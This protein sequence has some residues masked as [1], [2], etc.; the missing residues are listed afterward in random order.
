MMTEGYPDGIDQMMEDIR[1]GC[2]YRL[3]SG[4][5]QDVGSWA[6]PSI[7][8]IRFYDIVVKED[9]KDKVLASLKPYSKLSYTDAEEARRPEGYDVNEEPYLLHGDGGVK[10]GFFRKLIGIVFKKIGLQT[11]DW[12]KIEPSNQLGSYVQERYKRDLKEKGF[13]RR[14]HC[15][16]IILGQLKDPFVKDGKNKGRENT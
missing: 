4:A 11:I 1:N 12:D 7:R 16:N 9:I 10:I 14:W 2:K 15:H 3:N 6:Q 5:K 13:A 8:E